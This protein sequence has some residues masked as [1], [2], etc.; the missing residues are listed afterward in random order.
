MIYTV[1]L[2]PAID[3][4]VE[5]PG[6]LPGEVNRIQTLRTDVGG[7]GINVSKCLRSLGMP[8][9]AAA[10]FGGFTGE[11]ALAY[12]RDNGIDT[13]H[14]KI[15][16]DTRT[17]IKIIDPIQRKNTDINE[18]GPIVS[19]KEIDYL[20]AQ[21]A[22]V[23]KRNDIL[24]LAGSLPRGTDH[25][26]YRD[27]TSYFRQRGVLVFLDADGDNLRNAI[28]A[29]PYMIKPNQNELSDLMGTSFH[30]ERDII[31]AAKQLLDRGIS[32]VI[33]SM[34]SEGGLCEAGFSETE[35]YMARALQVPV[36]STVGAGDSM[37]AALAYSQQAG[38]SLEDEIRLAMAMGAASVMCDGTQAPE[39]QQIRQLSRQVT[40]ERIPISS[41]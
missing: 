3:K 12:L 22:A 8:S 13:I 7:K 41:I 36:R 23:I 21:I 16:G 15:S 18:P 4:T 37:V 14:V 24:I 38:L 5:I 27:W 10:L 6:F 17:N 31:L 32:K 33:V 11:Q 19:E 39:P 30:C 34:G 20:K 26:I 29:A 2:N 9:V 28:D 1:T 40:F 35:F 25:T